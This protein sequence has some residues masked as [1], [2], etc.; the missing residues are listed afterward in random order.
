MLSKESKNKIIDQ[1]KK[2]TNDVGSCE[3]QIALLSEK[4]KQLGEHL[5]ASPKDRHSQRGL[6][7]MVG[8]RKT[9]LNYLKKSDHKSYETVSQL[10]KSN[11]Y[12]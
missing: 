9:F 6:V 12:L 11:G 2:S 7:I 1:F 4:I 8:K 10:L 3:V 5:K